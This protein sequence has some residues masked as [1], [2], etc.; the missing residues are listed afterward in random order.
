MPERGGLPKGCRLGSPLGMC[1]VAIL[2]AGEPVCIETVGEH[3][4]VGLVV[5]TTQTVVYECIVV[6]A[7]VAWAK[8]NMLV[9]MSLG[10][11]VVTPLLLSFA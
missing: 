9:P 3:L 10:T 5:A 11:F 6:E 4:W 8:S 7:A 2:V 1:M